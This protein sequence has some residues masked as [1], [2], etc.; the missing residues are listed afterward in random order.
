MRPGDWKWHEHAHQ[1]AEQGRSESAIGNTWAERQDKRDTASPTVTR[2]DRQ[3]QAAEGQD[4]AEEEGG[5]TACP[6]LCLEQRALAV[7]LSLAAGV[8]GTAVDIKPGFRGGVAE[9]LVGCS[10]GGHPPRGMGLPGRDDG[11]FRPTML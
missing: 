4:Q 7:S 9:A 2:R 10:P 11:I 3:H 1:R 5:T 6:R 8:A